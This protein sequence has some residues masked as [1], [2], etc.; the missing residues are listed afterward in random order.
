MNGEGSSLPQA[1]GRSPTTARFP[2]TE[3]IQPATGRF[4]DWLSRGQRGGFRPS[5]GSV[6][7]P[8]HGGSHPPPS[9]CP[10]VSQRVSLR[11]SRVVRET[12]SLVITKGRRPF[13]RP[14]STSPGAVHTFSGAPHHPGFPRIPE[15]GGIQPASRRIPTVGVGGTSVWIVGTVDPKRWDS[16]PAVSSGSSHTVDAIHARREQRGVRRHEQSAA[17]RR[18]RDSL[19]ESR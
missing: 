14:R 9:H 19:A 17:G 5:L 3:R 10:A 6:L 18:R 1:V 2:Y 11:G 15:M 7:R 8:C 16:G 12:K 4:Q 13:E